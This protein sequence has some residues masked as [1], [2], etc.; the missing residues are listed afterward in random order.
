[1]AKSP[2]SAPFL[3][4][5]ARAEKMLGDVAAARATLASALAVNPANEFLWAIVGDLERDAGKLDA[6]EAAYR[7]AVRLSPRMASAWVA[8]GE[9]LARSGRAEEELAVLRAAVAAECESGVVFARLAEVELG[10]EELAAA[11]EHARRATELLPEWAA[12]WMVWSRV[13]SRQG[14]LEAAAERERR[15]LA[16]ARR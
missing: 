6:A 12:A 16:L 15:A 3:T 9:V 14:R 2:D 11:D 8:L 4:Q 5:L 10:R 1:V 7:E 13:A